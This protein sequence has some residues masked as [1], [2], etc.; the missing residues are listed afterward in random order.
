MP[1]I[2]YYSLIIAIAL[3]A[4]NFL[5]SVRDRYRRRNVGNGNDPGEGFPEKNPWEFPE[6]KD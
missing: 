4:V 6:N 3:I 1:R 5:R 2:V